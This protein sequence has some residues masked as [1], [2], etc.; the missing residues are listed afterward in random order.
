[1]NDS[2]LRI[3]LEKIQ[4]DLVYVLEEMLFDYQGEAKSELRDLIARVDQEPQLLGVEFSSR[5]HDLLSSA[6]KALQSRD[7]RKA[8]IMLL[9]IRRG[10]R[11]TL[12][13]LNG[14]PP[15]YRTKAALGAPG[16]QL[17]AQVQSPTQGMLR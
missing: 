1:M 6:L 10:L 12:L 13:V 4:D 14:L 11:N 9:E 2:A 8:N 17:T 7:T 16:W 15:L 5:L 3:E